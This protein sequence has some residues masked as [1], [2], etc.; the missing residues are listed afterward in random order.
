MNICL[1]LDIGASS[2]RAIAG[3][4]ENNQIRTLELSRFPNGVK[5]QDGHLV[6]DTETL[7]SNI[8]QAIAEAKKAYTVSSL[9]ID[10]WGVDYVL[11]R[12]KREVM[13]VYAYRDART[14]EAIREVHRVAPFSELY[15]RTGSQF[16]P[17]NSIYQLVADKM[18]GRLTDVTDFLMIPEYLLYKLTGVKGKE[19]TNAT[20]TGLINAKT[21]TFD[22]ELTDRL[23]LPRRLFPSLLQ[24]G[25]KLGTYEGIPVFL[26]CTHD[27]ASAV[28][29]IPMEENAPYISSGTWSLLGIKTP[30]PITDENS[31]KGN[32]SNE[33]GPGYNRYQKNIMGMWLVNELRR[34]LCPDKPFEEITKEA[35]ESTFAGTVDAD[36]PTFLAPES[37]KKAFAEALHTEDLQPADYFRCAYRSLAMSYRKALDEMESNLGKTFPCLYIVGGG[38]KN[39]FL[40]SLTAEITKKEIKALPIEASVLGNLKI[41]ME[42]LL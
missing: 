1:A 23:G 5:Q 7:L 15:S 25:T 10:T 40:N 31:R 13:P 41:Q 16:Q 36:A 20:T 14:E 8:R 12:G 30:K 22:T 28:E 26:C 2:G 39:T 9:S 17:F 37:M 6:W 34:E 3:W 35:S 21:L 38:A 19:F 27:T 18:A 33:G 32:W 29:G 24:P 4:K 11:L 42:N